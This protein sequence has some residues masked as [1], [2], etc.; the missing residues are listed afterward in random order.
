[1][2]RSTALTSVSRGLGTDD[3]GEVAFLWRREHCRER[4]KDIS[5]RIHRSDP[6]CRRRRCHLKPR[7]SESPYKSLDSGGTEA[8]DGWQKI[9]KTIRE[10][11]RWYNENPDAKDWQLT[12]MTQNNDS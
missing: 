5:R 9:G 6:F 12:V 7:F 11:V 1:M 3:A 10:N 4:T 8:G 2:V